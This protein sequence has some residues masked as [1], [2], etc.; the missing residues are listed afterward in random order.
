[1]NDGDAT[2]PAFLRPLHTDEWVAPVTTPEQSRA[3]ASARAG[4]RDIAEEQ[5]LIA[6]LAAAT[7]QATAIGL[8]AINAEW[9]SEFYEVGEDA[10]RSEESARDA[11][12]TPGPIVDVQTHFLAPHSA[13]AMGRDFLYGLYQSVMPGWWSEM[14]DVV[15]WTFAEYVR[16]VFV[17][18]ETAVAILTS[19]PGVLAS[20]NL[21][22]DE[23]AAAKLLFDEAGA[24]GRLLN[25]AVV[26]AEDQAE[27]A[28]MDEWRDEF[29]PVGWKVYTPGRASKRGWVNGWMLDDETNG[30][31]FLER[32]RDLDT[33]LVCAHKGISQLAE[34]GSPRDVGPAAKLFADI[35]FVIYHSGY[36][37]PGV[38]ADPEGAY[39]A[40]APEHF[41]VDRLLASVDAAEL[42][43]GA[44]VYAELG[45]TWFCLVSRPI[46]AAHVLGKLIKRLGADNVIWGSDS[47]WF[48]SPQPIIDA[49]RTF[50]IPAWMCENFGYERITDDVRAKILGGNAARVYGLDLGEVERLKGEH[51]R[52]WALELADR[53]EHGLVQAFR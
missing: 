53:Y 10:A 50:Q 42:P 26:H 15:A 8:R 4:V 17:E 29:G 22:N 49:F 36:E 19:G 13:A 20:R 44:N 37:M 48:G 18:S 46:E 32:V 21:F 5:H 41:G 47:I 30:V 1:M 38:A 12:A 31:P 16:N 39:V 25:H 28:M 23:M 24:H 7:R 27:V 33:K 52:S 34:N 14:D 3:K 51:D 2:V 43:Q 9:G 45:S 6:P 11:F 35:N 40:D